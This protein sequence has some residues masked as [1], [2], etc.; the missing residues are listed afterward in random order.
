MTDLNEQITTELALLQ[1]NAI[2]YR[3]LIKKDWINEDTLQV[4]PSAFFLRQDKAEFGI[5]VNIAN[6]CSPQDCASRFK[7]CGFVASL[8][9]GSVRDIGLDILQDKFNHANIIG[10]IYREDNLAEAE[11]L[12]GLLAKQSRIIKIKT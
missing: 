9:V 7:K 1:C 5:S 11:R 6:A 12:A 8:H 4:Q 2:V 10:L 3:A